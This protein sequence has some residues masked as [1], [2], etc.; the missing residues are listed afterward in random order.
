VLEDGDNITCGDA[1]FTALETPGHT[2]GTASYVYDV[3]G[4][5]ER[6]R[7][8]TV[9]GLGHNAI[10]GPGQ[11]DASINSVDRIA[12]LAKDQGDPL[13]IHLTMHGFSAN[14]E[15]N[16]QIL[17]T[18]KSGEANVFLN[19]QAVLDEVSFLRGGSVRRHEVELQ[20]TGE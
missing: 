9:G 3:F 11:V 16:R 18:R 1:S 5:G 20:K 7:A 17:A 15:E 10:E 12:A 19:A 6:H 14:L 2:W 4:H 8:I 13:M